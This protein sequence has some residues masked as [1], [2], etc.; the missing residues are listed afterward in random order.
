MTLQSQEIVPEYFLTG[1]PQSFW[2]NLE[3]E[4]GQNKTLPQGFEHQALLALSHFPEL[5]DV[6]VKFKIRSKGGPF[7]SRPTFWSTF[8]KGRKKRIYLILISDT[9]KGRFGPILLK[10]MPLGAQVGVLAHELGHTS[11][12]TERNVFGMVRV[13]AGNLSEKFLD[14]FEYANDRSVIEHGLGFQLHAWSSHAI[15]TLRVGEESP[16]KDKFEKVMQRERYMFPSTIREVMR[17]LPIYSDYLQDIQALES[18]AN[19]Q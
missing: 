19:A 17:S 18:K 13:I 11:Y 2:D 12:F 16:K 14:R 8:F 15:N 9:P 4:F 6:K 7:V 3:E 1:L 10:N 5:K